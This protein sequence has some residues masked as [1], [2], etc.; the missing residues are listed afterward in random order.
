MGQVYLAR[1]AD[2]EPVAIK[3]V[4]PDLAGDPDFRSRFEREV[5]A[6]RQVSGRYTVLVLDADVTGPVPWLATSY[7]AGPSLAAAVT[8]HGPLPVR[9]VLALAAGLAQGLA[10]IHAA[11]LVHRDLKPANVLLAADRPRL[12]DFG[13]SRA[14][15]VSTLTQTGL[16][17]G[18]P[19]FMSPEQA[20]GGKIGPASDVFSLGA[21]ITF[22]ATG[23]GPFGTGSSAALL[24]RVVY[25]RPFLGRLPAELRPLV[26]SC[27]AKDPG[28]RPATERL[29]AE[30]AEDLAADL[31]E[32]LT[33]DLVEDLT[34]GR[35]GAESAGWLPAPVG[36]ALAR[37]QPPERGS[38]PPGLVPAASSALAPAAS[39]A[40]AAAVAAQAGDSP[41]AESPAAGDSPAAT[42]AA[43]GQ[44][45]RRPRGRRDLVWLAVTTGLAAAAVAVML[46]PGSSTGSLLSLPPT[47]KAII[48]QP[49]ATQPPGSPAARRAAPRNGVPEAGPVDSGLAAPAGPSPALLIP[50]P[51][52]SSPAPKPTHHR[53]TGS[54]SPRPSGQPSGSPSPDPGTSSPSPDP[55]PTTPTPDPSTS[56]P[57]PVSSTSSA[58]A[59]S[60]SAESP[61]AASA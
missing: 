40:S 61:S 14:A 8:E 42:G 53:S 31:A 54:P 29:L 20:E 52:T 60:P 30:L 48:A 24:Y 38:Q 36:A 9:S 41:A 27:L 59:E 28:H 39:P 56:T 6:A 32:D 35:P 55:G 7:I 21:V 5:A 33:A 43:G 3:M 25:S 15:E 34:A 17:V 51:A 4:R 44:D 2:G 18:S 23:E 45:R 12:I 57:A 50:H 16:I 26:E 10:E 46:V 49:A 58:A 11:G 13:I 47:E 22:A 37:Y 19:G 1:C